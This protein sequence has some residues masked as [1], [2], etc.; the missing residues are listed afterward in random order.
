MNNCMEDKFSI[1]CARQGGSEIETQCCL[2][3]QDMKNATS[4][5]Q[6]FSNN[7]FYL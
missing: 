7:D 5:L 2:I 3:I 6:C 1:Y 4:L